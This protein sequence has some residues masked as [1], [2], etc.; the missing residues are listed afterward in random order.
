MLR[1]LRLRKDETPAWLEYSVFISLILTAT[2]AT[3][4]LVEALVGGQGT[5]THAI[6]Q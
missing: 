3:V 5:A 4:F 6:T 2:I 1:F